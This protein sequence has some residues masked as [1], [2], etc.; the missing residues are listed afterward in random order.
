[1][2]VRLLLTHLTV[3]QSLWSFSQSIAVILPSSVQ[4][5][6]PIEYLKRKLWTNEISA[7]IY[8]E[9]ETEFKMSFGNISYIAQTLQWR[10]NG[11]DG[12]SNH[13]PHDCLPNRLFKRRPK[14]TLKLCVTGLCVGNSP[15]T[16][17]FLAQMAGKAENVSILCCHHE[18]LSGYLFHGNFYTGTASIYIMT[19]SKMTY[20]ES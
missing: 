2:K 16:G 7:D 6:K 4:I 10:H 8:I 15:V 14:K 1:M 5:I 12:V 19:L 9:R 13:Q 11:H 18:S 3:S 17:E 20:L